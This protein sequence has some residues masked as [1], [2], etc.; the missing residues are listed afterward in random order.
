MVVDLGAMNLLVDTSDLP[1]PVLADQCDRVSVYGAFDNA[2]LWDAREID[3]T[4]VVIF[5]QG[6]A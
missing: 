1:S 3:A 2:D 4:S 6:P 5:S